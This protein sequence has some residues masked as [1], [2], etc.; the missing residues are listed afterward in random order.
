MRI[1]LEYVTEEKKELEYHI[2]KL[3]KGVNNLRRNTIGSNSNLL[4][5]GSLNSFY[6]IDN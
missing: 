1:K 6:K 3:K 4:N 2:I 5:T